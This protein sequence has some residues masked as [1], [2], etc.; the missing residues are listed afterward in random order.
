MNPRERGEVVMP[1][2]SCSEP[3]EHGAP[4]LNKAREIRDPSE[5]IW[6]GGATDR[7]G[8][9]QKNPCENGGANVPTLCGYCRGAGMILDG[10]FGQPMLCPDCKGDGLQRG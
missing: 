4:A 5:G 9:A 2:Q 6:V 10:F 1:E 7:S 3:L 8:F